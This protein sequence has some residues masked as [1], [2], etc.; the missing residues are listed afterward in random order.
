[1]APGQGRDRL[2]LFSTTPNDTPHALSNW[3]WVVDL[4]RSFLG[5]SFL[6]YRLAKGVIYGVKCMSVGND[7]IVKM[8]SR[9]SIYYVLLRRGWLNEVLK[10]T[11]NHSARMRVSFVSFLFFLVVSYWFLRQSLSIMEEERVYLICILGEGFAY[12]TGNARRAKRGMG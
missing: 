1:M 7:G 10:I 11:S 4:R 6:Y 9:C 5:L 12:M 3:Q 8:V 2:N